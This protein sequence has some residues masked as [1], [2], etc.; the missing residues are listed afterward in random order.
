[1]IFRK[2]CV[3]ICVKNCAK[4]LQVKSMFEKPVRTPTKRE[5][6]LIKFKVM[7][8]WGFCGNFYEAG[9]LIS[10]PQW[11][12]V[13]SKT[14]ISS[15]MVIFPCRRNF[16]ASSSL[17]FLDSISWK[18]ASPPTRP[19]P[20]ALS[21]LPCL[22]AKYWIKQV[23]AITLNPLTA[24]LP[25]SIERLGVEWNH[26]PRAPDLTPAVRTFCSRLSRSHTHSPD[27]KCWWRQ[28]PSKDLQ[29]WW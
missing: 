3:K 1:M 23:S 29:L 22:P 2:I 17:W 16:L 27:G 14:K 28:P 7:W 5:S 8:Q 4:N 20:H 6:N 26:V 18:N 19:S 12:Q 21:L 15:L 11:E 10:Y 25:R 24:L 13:R 9:D